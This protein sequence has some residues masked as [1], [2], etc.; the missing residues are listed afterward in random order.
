MSRRPLALARRRLE[1]RQ[2]NPRRGGGYLND[3]GGGGLLRTK[4]RHGADN[5]LPAD[6]GRL[7]RLALPH[8]R[9][10]RDHAALREIDMLDAFALLVQDLAL[11]QRKVLEVRREQRQI[12]GAER[13]QQ[14]IAPLARGTFQHHCSS[15]AVSG[16]GR[17]RSERAQPARRSAASRK[18]VR[19]RSP[20]VCAVSDKFCLCWQ[21]FPPAADPGSER[22]PRQGRWRG[23]TPACW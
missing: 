19:H 8:H 1:A 18:V 20:H 3:G 10:Q 9:K 22:S 7:H 6:G 12:L 4:R 13:C 16:S 21:R 2:R 15:I 5:A 14:Q 11:P 17:N 23:R